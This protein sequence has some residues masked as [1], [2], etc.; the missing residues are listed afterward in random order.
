MTMPSR[1]S[2]C[3][4][5]SAFCVLLGGCNIF[6]A[7]PEPPDA[8]APPVPTVSR[9]KPTPQLLVKYLNDEA[10]KLH[11]IET[12]DLQIDV[13]VP[14]SSVSLESGS[15]LCQKPRF[16]RLTGK[17]L[18]MQ[19]V[20]VGSNDDR[21]WF[22]VKQ[23]PSDALYHCSYTD[24]EKGAVDLPFPFEPEWVLEALGMAHT[25]ASPS[26]KV[27]DDKT[28]YRLIEDTTMRGKPV[29]RVTVFYKG[30]AR[31]EQPQVKSRTLYD[32]QD[33]VICAATIKTVTRIPV[34]RGA[35]TKSTYV[36]CPQIVKLEWPAQQT[37][38]ILDLG[39]MKV[40][41]R[42]SMESFQ[43]PRLGSKQ[44]D[45]GRDRPTGRGVVPAQYR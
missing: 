10:D 8:K 44:V 21:F 23:D 20:L 24:F 32:S 3:V 19:Q 37:E 7:R 36:T 30:N 2:I 41:E 12:H 6:R 31:G 45:L 34:E 14:G 4:L 39:R 26:M 9:D 25:N 43:M 42:L 17:K 22:Y 33:K 18:G 13:R 11:S 35:N 15:L 29:R 16:F 5:A 38:L 40:N 28:T 27:E 1:R